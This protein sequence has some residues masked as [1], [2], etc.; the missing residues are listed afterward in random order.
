MQTANLCV[1]VSVCGCVRMCVRMCELASERANERARTI[2][3][4]RVLL[5]VFFTARRPVT[6]S[7]A[8]MPLRKD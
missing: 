4:V 1:C 8:A 6:L 2:V 3:T 7:A 5:C